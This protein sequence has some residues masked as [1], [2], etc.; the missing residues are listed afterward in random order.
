MA[1]DF[2]LTIISLRPDLRR[3][4]GL[5]P[6]LAAGEVA[7]VV[8]KRCGPG[9][10]ADAGRI[11]SQRYRLSPAEV[12]LV[13]AMDGRLAL[14]DVAAALGISYETARWH[15]KR[16]FAKLGISRQAELVAMVLALKGSALDQ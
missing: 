1:G 9:G 5:T 10:P 8:M 16:V 11:L 6:W 14:S 2:A 3:N 12:R 13:L 15:L 7:L 4:R